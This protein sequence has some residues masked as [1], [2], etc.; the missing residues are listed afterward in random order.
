MDT[1]GDAS[2]SPHPDKASGADFD[3]QG[4]LAAIPVV[5][6]DRHGQIKQ[7]DILDFHSGDFI[8]LLLNIPGPEREIPTFPSSHARPRRTLRRQILKITRKSM[9]AVANIQIGI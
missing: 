9:I 2:H 7:F 6:D 8:R 4:I 5:A 3:Q 1:S